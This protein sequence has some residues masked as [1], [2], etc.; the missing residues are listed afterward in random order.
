M[1]IWYD[2]WP[3]A[4]FLKKSQLL[5]AAGAAWR[6]HET[7][8]QNQRNAVTNVVVAALVRLLCD[9]AG[10]ALLGHRGEHVV[11]EHNF[12]PSHLGHPRSVKAGGLRGRSPLTSISLSVMRIGATTL[13]GHKSSSAMMWI[14][15]CVM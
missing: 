8:L 9:E 1:F 5:S 4:V 11:V 3:L 14:M 10:H 6:I 15:S 2:C 12:I 7:V 13:V